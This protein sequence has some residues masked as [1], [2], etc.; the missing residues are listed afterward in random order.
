MFLLKN[1]WTHLRWKGRYSERDLPSWTEDL[2]K[3][4]DYNPL[5]AQQF[6]DG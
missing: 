1:P 4:L 2:K 3:A 6:D 5:D